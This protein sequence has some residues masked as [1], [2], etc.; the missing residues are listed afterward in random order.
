[1]SFRTRRPKLA[2]CLGEF[3]LGAQSK[4]KPQV[5]AGEAGAGKGEKGAKV[6]WKLCDSNCVVFT[7]KVFSR[8][9]KNLFGVFST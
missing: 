2:Q 3:R 9:A 5:K 6:D 8:S 4:A 7:L 1:M